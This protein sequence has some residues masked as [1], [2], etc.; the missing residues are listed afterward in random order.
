MK[1][2]YIERFDSE[3]ER[4]GVCWVLMSFEPLSGW[5]ELV[6]TERRRKQEFALAMRRLAEEHYP[7]AE[8][9]QVVL[10]NLSTHT[11][12][13]FYE[14]F[15]AELA[16]KLA[17]RLACEL[18]GRWRISHPK[19]AEHLEEHIEECLSCLA[20]PESHR[21]R[22]R[23]T[24]GLER[25]NQEI[26][27][28]TRVVRIFPNRQACLRLVSALAVEQSEEWLTGRRYLDM[29][30]LEEYRPQERDTEGVALMER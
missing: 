11:G 25:L 6:V 26:K 29:Q 5:R 17:L 8:K 15:S 1:P 30:E 4:G 18:A 19:V 7:Q 20:F 21:R 27:R 24:N 10:D 23:T 12:A 13:A 22:I 28:R 9:I 14:S 2:G 3:Y 16:R